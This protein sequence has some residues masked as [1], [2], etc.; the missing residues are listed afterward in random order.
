MSEWNNNELFSAA[1]SF[2]QD[3]SIKESP[4]TIDQDFQVS[5]ITHSMYDFSNEFLNYQDPL[6]HAYKH[7]FQPFNLD[8][9]LTHQVKSHFVEGYFRNDG[10][11]VEGYYRDGDG[12]T[13]INHSVEQGGG[14][15]RSNPD[16]NPLN[17]L[18]K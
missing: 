8:I 18:N 3:F 7:E 10:T 4:N 5:E 2:D 1:D 16:E 17:N 15:L 6:K 12:N 13:A 14:Y 11:Y 9:D